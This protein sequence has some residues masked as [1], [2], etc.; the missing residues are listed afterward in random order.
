M[1]HNRRIQ[2]LGSL[3]AGRFFPAVL[4]LAVTC[5]LPLQAQMTTGSDMEDFGKTFGI[6]AKGWSVQQT[7]CS[8]GANALWPGEEATFT[9]FLKPGEP[10]KGPL[11]VDVVQYGTK[12]KPGDWWKPIVFKIADTS[13]STLD[14]DLPAGGGTVT[15]KPK[16]GEIFGGY[17]LIFDLGDRGRAFCRHLCPSPHA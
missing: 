5:A 1:K 7:E 3:A 9:F 14:V 10:Y 2:W 13:S 15:V 8:L 12:G 4:W 11:K 6:S 16:I 17:A